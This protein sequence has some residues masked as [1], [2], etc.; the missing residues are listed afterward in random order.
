[1]DY[2]KQSRYAHISTVQHTRSH[3][4]HVTD[5]T[6][7]RT[8]LPQSLPWWKKKKEEKINKTGVRKDPGRL[9][10]APTLSRYS[11]PNPSLIVTPCGHNP[12]KGGVKNRE[13]FLI[14]HNMINNEGF[15]G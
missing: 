12:K 10:Q 2:Q 6:A 5:K 1:M 13:P 15:T 3:P 11:S 9:S 4:F 7:Q 8:H 14:S